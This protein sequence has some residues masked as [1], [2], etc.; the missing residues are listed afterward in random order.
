M[1]PWSLDDNDDWQ[2]PITYPSIE[3]DGSDQEYGF[4]LFLG[5]KQNI[6]QTTLKVGKQ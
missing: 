2:A 3:D 4:I 6:T 5:T 1:L